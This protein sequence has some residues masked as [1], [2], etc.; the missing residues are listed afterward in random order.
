MEIIQKEVF[1]RIGRDHQSGYLFIGKLRI[2]NLDEKIADLVCQRLGMDP[3][4]LHD[5]TCIIKK[6]DVQSIVGDDYLAE[7]VV[8]LK[9]AI[10]IS[11]EEC[12]LVDDKEAKDEKEELKKLP[13]SP[14]LVEEKE[15]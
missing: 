11:V 8:K 15:S 2:G 1:C 5:K 7:K 12:E 3:K 10:A 9:F 14:T 13:E 4:E 6:F